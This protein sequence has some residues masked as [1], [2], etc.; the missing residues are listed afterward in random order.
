[1][2]FCGHDFHIAITKYPRNQTKWEEANLG[3]VFPIYPNGN[4]MV[5]QITWFL[6]VRVC[7]IY[8]LCSIY[9]EARILRQNWDPVMTL[10]DL[11]PATQFPHL[12]PIS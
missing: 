2:D 4:G 8:L 5:D 12:G 6:P 11:P 3:L 7:C 1:M 9:Q 10:T